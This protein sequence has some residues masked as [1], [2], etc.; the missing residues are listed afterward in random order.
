MKLKNNIY[1]LIVNFSKEIKFK[2]KICWKLPNQK[3]HYKLNQ[4]QYNMKKLDS[5]KKMTIK[6]KK[7]KKKEKKEKMN[8]MIKMMETYYRKWW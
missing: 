4:N 1:N 5:V 3:I 8:L 7:M 6:E 2:F